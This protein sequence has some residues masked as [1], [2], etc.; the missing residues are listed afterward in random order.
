MVA[1]HPH[2]KIRALERGATEKEVIDVVETGEVFPA[3]YGRTT[4]RK[5]IIFNDIWQGKHF[6]VKQI[7]CYAVKENEGWLVI[8]L[9]VKY[10]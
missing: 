7:E 4:F 1:I 5:S 2:A 8:S 10:F 6:Y 9:L 3:K